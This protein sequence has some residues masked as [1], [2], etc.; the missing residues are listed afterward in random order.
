MKHLLPHEKNL[1]FRSY[2]P[3]VQKPHGSPARAGLLDRVLGPLGPHDAARWQMA[4]HLI[5]QGPQQLAQV[6]RSAPW[7]YPQVLSSIGEAHLMLGQLEEGRRVMQ[8]ALEVRQRHGDPDA[9]GEILL[10]LCRY[11][12]QHGDRAAALSYLERLAVTAL[13]GGKTPMFLNLSAA[14]YEAYREREEDRPRCVKV[15]QDALALLLHH[16][17]DPAMLE[18]ALICR[19]HLATELFLAKDYAGAR[20]QLG[21]VMPKLAI[22]PKPTQEQARHLHEQ[23]LFLLGDYAG[24]AVLTEEQLAQARARGDQGA[25]RAGLC[26][27]G[28]TYLFADQPADA[29]RC[30]EEALEIPAAQGAPESTVRANLGA[31]QLSLGQPE[32]ARAQL[33]RALSLLPPEDQKGRYTVLGNLGR[34]VWALGDV[35]RAVGL[36]KEALEGARAAGDRHQEAEHLARLGDLHAELG[37]SR[38]ALD[39]YKKNLALVSE[40]GDQLGE[41]LALDRLGQTSAEVAGPARAQ[42]YFEW[43]A[44]IAR[45][46]DAPE[47]Q[48]RALFRLGQLHRGCGDVDRALAA[49][50]QALALLKQL[51]SPRAQEVEQVLAEWDAPQP[52]PA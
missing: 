47:Q 23:A 2:T 10:L 51:G 34:A 19:V 14:L 45:E 25:V 49:T 5:A 7:L 33:E 4:R 18:Q 20:E 31:A 43:M 22:L 3:A 8:Q 12:D 9:E 42:K 15:L 52:A 50:Q 35:H 11:H 26:D 40:L 39:Y 37:T 48:A 46:N 13:R 1:L 38:R 29:A 24:A 36:L 44:A 30:L 41:L 27:L 21:E 28:V 16:R 17:R 32:Q 6:Q